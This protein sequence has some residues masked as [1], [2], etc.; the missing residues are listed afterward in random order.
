MP[1]LGRR[2]ALG[3]H[4]LKDESVSQLIAEAAVREMNQH[5][6]KQLLEIG[7]GKGAIT[8]PILK[9]I[10][11]QPSVDFQKFVLVE[12][13]RV[14]AEKW[15]NTQTFPFLKLEV[16]DFLELEPPR[17]LLFTPLAVVSNLPYSAGTAI[18]NRLARFSK[19]IPVMVLMFQ[20][21]V[22]QRLRAEEGEKSRGSLSV[23]IQNQWDVRKLLFVPPRAFSPPPEVNS[24]VIVLT[25][26]ENPR[27]QDSTNPKF[28]SLWEGL[29]KGAFAHRRQML[30]KVLKTS[31]LWRNAL[32]VS[33]V[34]GT[35]RAESLQWE[36]W[37]RLFQVVRRV[38][39]LSAS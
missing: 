10:Q 15:L 35:K 19:D 5:H 28:E 37:D 30:R 23:W 24:E 39:N 11:Q 2:R 14:L 21:E 34:D 3:Q 13:D 38:S 7:P 12:R 36:E 18:L 17:W 33:E 1:T 4:F 26:R 8:Q 20:A 29:L 22:A 27:I 6:C 31:E 32:E 25:R 9:L 16:G